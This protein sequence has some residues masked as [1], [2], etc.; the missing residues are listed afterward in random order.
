VFDSQDIST[1]LFSIALL[2]FDYDFSGETKK[3]ECLLEIHRLLFEAFSRLPRESLNMDHA[4][5]QLAKY[6]NLLSALTEDQR[7]KIVGQTEFVFHLQ[8]PPLSGKKKFLEEATDSLRTELEKENESSFAV[9]NLFYGLRNQ[10]YPV[11]MVVKDKKTGKLLLF[12]ELSHESSDYI[13]TTGG[14]HPGE[15]MLSRNNQFK[16]SLYRHYY[17]EVPLKRISLKA[18]Q[19]MESIAEEILPIVKRLKSTATEPIGIFDSVKN[20]LG[21]I[22]S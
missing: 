14:G 17:P 10:V 7:T 20:A 6:F 11:D 5:I 12:I 13:L 21:N 4:N 15:R 19:S 3:T 9:E 8:N 22:F 18:T 1:S 2:S 16:E